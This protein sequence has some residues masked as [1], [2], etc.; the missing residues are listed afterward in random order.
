M[1]F[2]LGTEREEEASCVKWAGGEGTWDSHS[3]QK[4]QLGLAQVCILYC[5]R[6]P[7]AWDASLFREDVIAVLSYV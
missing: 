6:K 4:K 3:R 7:L 2:N 1:A 5:S